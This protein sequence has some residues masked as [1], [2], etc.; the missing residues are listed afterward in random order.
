M[1]KSQRLAASSAISAGSS[2]LAARRGG[3][4]RAFAGSP[5]AAIAT[6]G[7]SASPASP[8][9]TRRTAAPGSRGRS[10][11]SSKRAPGPIGNWLLSGSNGSLGWPSTATMRVFAP[12]MATVA[13]R[14]VAALPSLQAHARAGAG[15]ELQRRG[16]AVG[17]DEAPFAP[18]C[19]R[20]RRIGEVVL[21]LAVRVDVPVG[22]HDRRV[23][24]DIG[25]DRLL[26]DDRPEEPAPL[27][28]GVGCAAHAG[29]RD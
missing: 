11:I 26:D 7:R 16:G 5:S 19:A 4:E 12:S 22:E 24:I 23:E 14:A 29:D 18:A 6:N 20:D 15:A 2:G 17:E 8:R 1:A 21:D 9:R 10:N 25:L 28:A 13:R 27:L 3:A